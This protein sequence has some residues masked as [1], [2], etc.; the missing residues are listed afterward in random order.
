MKRLYIT[1]LERK[2]LSNEYELR[3]SMYDVIKETDKS[4]FIHKDSYQTRISKDDL[5]TVIHNFN[6]ISIIGLDPD[7]KQASEHQL[8]L[9]SYKKAVLERAIKS[10]NEQLES[11]MK[12]LNEIVGE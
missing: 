5:D 2:T 11:V 8:K 3:V 12:F 4:Y 10:N 9:L 6:S 1:S 7:Q